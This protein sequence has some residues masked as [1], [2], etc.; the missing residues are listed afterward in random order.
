MFRCSNRIARVNG[1]RFKQGFTLVELLVVIG[2][3]ALLISILLPSLARA[4]QSAVTVACM[5]GLRQIGMGVSMYVN[6]NRG[7]LPYGF[8]DGNTPF[9]PGAAGS[10]DWTTLIAKTLDTSAADGY[11]N[12]A[13][14]VIGRKMFFCP[15][16][17]TPLTA[18]SIVNH[19]ACHPRL[20]PDLAGND[21]S[22][23]PAKLVSSYKWTHL[24]RPS[25]AALIFDTSLK[26]NASGEQTAMSVNAWW[27]DNGHLFSSTYLTDNYALDPINSAPG[28]WQNSQNSIDVTANSGVISDSNK[29]VLGNPA[30]IRF[31]H[32]YNT[33]ANSLMGDGHVES[34]ILK[35]RY[36]TTLPRGAVNVNR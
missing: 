9:S 29:D 6:G 17:A 24:K 18:N 26:L 35:D 20:M 22:F 28:G 23:S 21:Y 4:R 12:L 2:I 33:I 16:V 7:S 14:N 5:S 15:G 34:F 1:A 32:M 19:Y 3:I 11:V 8:W 25:E 13:T 31:R 27:L 30:N 10:G 36:T